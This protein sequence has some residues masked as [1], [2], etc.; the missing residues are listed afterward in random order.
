MRVFLGVAMT[1]LLIGLPPVRQGDFVD[2]T[3]PPEPSTP[4]ASQEKTPLPYGCKELLPGIIADGW[5][6]R[7][8][9]LPQ[10]IVV[11]VVSVSNMKP[12]LGSGLEAEVRLRNTDT[13]PL[14]IPWNRDPRIIEHGQ[15]P[16]ALVWEVGTFEFTLKDQ[17]GHQVSLKS[18]T[19]SLYAPN[20]RQEANLP[21]SQEKALRP[22]SN[23]NWMR[24]FQSRPCD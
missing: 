20:S 2:L 14:Q 4:A 15:S 17:Q 3:Q 9:N 7:E 22:R 13:R 8:D 18:L 21:S 24:N 11:E 19:E 16:D 10:D 5:V 23:S 12:S 1:F 6:E